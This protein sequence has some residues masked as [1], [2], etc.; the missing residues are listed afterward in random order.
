MSK[1]YTNTENS[2]YYRPSIYNNPP[3][4]YIPPP[5]NKQSWNGYPDYNNQSNSNY[6][7]NGEGDITN[8][9]HHNGRPNG[10]IPMNSI[11][12]DNNGYP[13]DK[14]YSKYN[15]NL[16]NS[17]NYTYSTQN[18]NAFPNKYN[19]PRVPLADPQTPKEKT[20]RKIVLIW[21]LAASI[22][23]ITPVIVGYIIG[24]AIVRTTLWTLGFYGLVIVIHYFI[25]AMFAY[26]NYCKVTRR[27][28]RRRK[29]WTGLSTGLLVVG[30]RED[31]ELFRGCLKSITYLR[32]AKN[33]RIIVVVDGNEEEDRYMGDIFSKVFSRWDHRVITTDFRLQDIEMFEQRAIKLVEE[34][35]KCMGPVCIM[36]PHFGKRAA[37][38]T[39][40]Q[41]L[42]QCQVE[43]VVVTDSDTILDTHCIKELAFMLDDNFVGAAT[44]DVRIWNTGTMLS[45]LS[46]LRY[47]FA[48]N[49]ERSAQSFQNCVTCVSGP[50]GIYRSD[51]L[52]EIID[53]WINQRFLGSLCTYGDD[54]HLTNLTLALGRYVK[55]TPY[56]FCYTETPETFIR[57]VTQQ[58]RWS[59]SFYREALFSIKAIP[60]QSLWM[61]Y[62]ILFHIIYPF[63]LI[64]S[65]LV[66]VYKGTLWQMIVWILTLFIMGGLRTIYA[67]LYTKKLKF[68]F[69]IF[70][71]VVYLIGFI[72]AKI[73]ALLFLWDNG[74]GTSSRLKKISKWNQKMIPILWIIVLIVGIVINI[75]RFILS[76]TEK[77]EIHHII[78][79]IILICTLLIGFVCYCFYQDHEKKKRVAREQERRKINRDQNISK[80]HSYIENDMDVPLTNTQDQY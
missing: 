21:T 63:I 34:V 36:Q 70:Y 49:L 54:R 39:G 55:F 43:A 41:V 2:Q 53:K 31:P 27:K 1:R 19:A 71:G 33:E 67:L 75:R 8:A 9:Y 77:F 66:L 42:L 15:P 47:W 17:A 22:L 10:D 13:D 59:K 46:S 44:G 30:Y 51:V 7:N 57:W 4:D 3:S 14:S 28:N 48:F 50:L 16:Q 24:Q 76:D 23:L 74:W 11:S 60:V 6:Y 78:G 80:Y 37:M 26:L 18:V 58:T 79:L 40:F 65:L 64:Y 72:P 68:L 32:Y 62:E 38:Y 56:A 25:Q 52:R 20:Q 61:T 12:I 5:K 29:D 73:Q 45:F 35:K 69:N